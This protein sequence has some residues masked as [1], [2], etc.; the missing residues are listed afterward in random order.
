MTVDWNKSDD[1]APKGLKKWLILSIKLRKPG[2][3]YSGLSL[4]KATF[5]KHGFYPI[6]LINKNPVFSKL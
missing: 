6:Y 5:V 1:T 4:I 3:I 2:F